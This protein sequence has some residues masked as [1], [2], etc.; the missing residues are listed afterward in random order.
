MQEINFTCGRVFPEYTNLAIFASKVSMPILPTAS[1]YGKT[2]LKT[3]KNLLQRY[4][5]AEITIVCVS[6]QQEIFF[7]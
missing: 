6:R 1:N 3:W 2:R 7:L 5:V 4:D